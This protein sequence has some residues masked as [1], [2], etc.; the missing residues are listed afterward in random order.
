[1]LLR[2]LFSVTR[3][4]RGPVVVLATMRSD[5]LNPFQLF[6]GASEEY[7]KITLDPMPKERF[8]KVIEGPAERFGLRR[9]SGLTE[10]LVEDT[11]YDDALP[12]LAFTLKELYGKCELDGRLSIKAY[13]ALFPPI[14]LEDAKGKT[15]EY[16]G[17]T[18]AIKHVADKILEHAHYQGL[19]PDSARLRDLR[20]AFHLL[21]QVGEADQVTKR[22][23][24]WSQMPA[25]C[26]A[27]L[28][29]LVD[30]RLLVSDTEADARERTLSVAHEALF[31]VWDT[32]R[33]W[34]YQD[35]NA[36]RLFFDGPLALRNW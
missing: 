7:E 12:L 17:V 4:L 10:R 6:P 24:R 27:V 23:A 18:A 34:L 3:P 5:F 21:A 11:A 15:T 29:L 28:Q 9:D 19:P 8:G 36:L 2:L 26:E 30:K 32:L 31:R 16:R 35:R 33:N 1:M 14:E 20:R 25:S 13:E 22:K